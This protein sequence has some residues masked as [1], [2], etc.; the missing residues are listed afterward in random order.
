VLLNKMSVVT[1]DTKMP[2]KTYRKRLCMLMFEHLNQ[3][4]V[5]VEVFKGT[6]LS[7]FFLELKMI[8]PTVS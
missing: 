6:C 8:L 5:P 4:S 3:K 1:G 7:W 2:L